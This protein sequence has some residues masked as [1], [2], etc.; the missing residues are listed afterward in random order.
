MHK[1][2]KRIAV[3]ILTYNRLEFLQRTLNSALD[4]SCKDFHIYV[5]NDNSTDGTSEYLKELD[6]QK[7]Y[8]T[9]INNEENLGQF[10]NANSVLDSI[11]S[12]FIMFLH[13]D[14]KIGNKHLKNCLELIDRDEDIAVVGTGWQMIDAEGKIIQ[15]NK[16]NGFK[17]QIILSDSDFIY[18]HIRGLQFP[19]S[20]TLIRAD[21]IGKTKFDYYYN[22]S[23]DIP[24][25][26][27]IIKGNKTGFIPD[28]TFS[29]RQHD[30]QNSAV[31][32]FE[33]RYNEWIRIFDFY[34]NYLSGVNDTKEN[35]KA[36]KMA[37][38]KT[39]FMN[40]M[41]SP[42]FNYYFKILSDYKYFNIFYLKPLNW[43]RVIKKFLKLL[44][45]L[46]VSAKK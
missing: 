45:Q 34:S 5:F 6:K 32:S 31:K 40:L 18:Q 29:Y 14:D 27:N 46:P 12:E 44:F 42:D 11:E 36:L 25:L 10:R 39:S 20:G 21:K 2:N 43:L 8:I 24:F 7:D 15:I 9:V 16:Y 19:W 37:N 38:T 30:E 17:H 33:D 3:C 23:A 13:D 22:H 35:R 4:S 26:L 41:D 28:A 1:N